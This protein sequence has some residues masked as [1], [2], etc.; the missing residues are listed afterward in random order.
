MEGKLLLNVA[1]KIIDKY[2]S[3]RY[4]KEG[5]LNVFELFEKTLDGLGFCMSEVGDLLSQWRGYA[6]DGK[7]FSIGFSKEYLDKLSSEDTNNKHIIRLHKVLYSP[8]EQIA[9]VAPLLEQIYNDIKS[10]DVAIPKP[11]AIYLEEKDFDEYRKSNELVFKK[12][13]V[14]LAPALGKI[15]AFKNR[16]FSEESEWR[17]VSFM[18][19]SGEDICEFKSTADRIIPCRTFDMRRLEVEPIREIIIGPKNITPTSIIEKLLSTHGYK[20][21]GVIRSTSTYR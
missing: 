1:Q 8:E 16:A 2:D 4:V 10:G 21:I 5:I 3:D 15:F 17:M 6:D 11:R 18:L 13:F 12:L 20:N 19:N 9:V 14:K 7:G